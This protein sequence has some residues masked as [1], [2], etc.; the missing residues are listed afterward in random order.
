MRYILIMAL[1]IFMA[2]AACTE[3]SVQSGSESDGDVTDGDAFT[4]GDA[5]APEGENDQ[6]F[7]DEDESTD[8]DADAPEGAEA[9]AACTPD[10]YRCREDVLEHCSFESEWEFYRDCALDGMEC[11]AGDC[12]QSPDGDEEAEPDMEEIDGDG[13]ED[14]DDT[15]NEVEY[16]MENEIE[17]DSE[18]ESEGWD[19]DPDDVVIGEECPEQGITL[20]IHQTIFACRFDLTWIEG[21][22]CT[23]DGIHYC[24]NGECIDPENTPDYPG[25][26]HGDSYC[27]GDIII[28]CNQN[29]QWI[30][31]AD[32]SVDGEHTCYLGE[33]IQQ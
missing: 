30:T 1:F 27:S 28:A 25:C 9:D 21:V 24:W 19:I 17:A 23:D 29:N 20:C 32:C 8:G 5:D 16:E 18:P 12:I 6:A 3:T 33:C 26:V 31:G 7:G 13:F 15:E 14:A 10:D 2:T 11:A 4:D 22:R